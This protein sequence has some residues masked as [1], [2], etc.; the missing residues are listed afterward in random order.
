MHS[1]VVVSKTAP[2][3]CLK[4]ANDNNACQQ[5]KRRYPTR[6]TDF[7]RTVRGVRKG[8]CRWLCRWEERKSGEKE[9]VK[10]ILPAAL[11]GDFEEDF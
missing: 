11:D 6:G 4:H 2:I 9:N 3:L 7:R 1:L 5:E 10:G 8:G